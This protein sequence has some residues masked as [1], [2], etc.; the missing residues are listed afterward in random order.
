MTVVRHAAVAGQFY[1]ADA[2][3]LGAG[4]KALLDEA[5]APRGPAPKA[6]IVPHAGYQYSGPVA[7]VAYARLRA[8]RERYRRVV[9]LGPCHYVGVRGLAFSGADVFR[10]P[11]GDVHLSR[12][13]G[14]V[15]QHPATS[16]TDATHGPEHSLEVQLPFLQSVLDDFVLIPI[17]VGQATADSVADVLE[18]LWGGPETLIV[19]STD[20]S[21][22]QDYAHARKHDGA[23]CAA[24][25]E[26]TP[27]RIGSDDACGAF[28]L[29]GLLTVARRKRLEVRTLDLRNSG[30]TA[31]SRE[32]VVGYGAW[33]LIDPAE[34][35]A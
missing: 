23:T 34:A 33:M 35:K 1:P 19:V 22:Y 6:L 5:G 11:L 8:H 24:I 2:E 9:L 4:V 17:V 15:L 12:P 28:A 16:F 21:H 31:G 27:E 20:L 14:D 13:A 18:Q 29:N 30:D 32:R 7:A 25:E 10:T 26:L 3:R